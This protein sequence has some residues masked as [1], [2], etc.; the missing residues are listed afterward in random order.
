M[1]YSGIRIDE[2][3]MEGEGYFVEASAVI[4]AEKLEFVFCY[5]YMD[6]AADYT[7]VKATYTPNN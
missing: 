1:N 3:E 5:D 7:R 2:W 4:S 6:Y